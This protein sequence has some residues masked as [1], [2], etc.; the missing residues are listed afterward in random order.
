MT[1]FRIY[2]GA[3]EPMK[4]VGVN[5]VRLLKF[6]EKYKGWHT[7]SGDRATL[8]AIVALHAK[9]YLEVSWE[10]QMFKFKYPD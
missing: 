9:D 4:A 3:A 8:R 7:Y 2:Y 6:A 5:Q 10:N 1:T